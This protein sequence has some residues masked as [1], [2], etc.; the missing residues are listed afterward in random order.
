VAAPEGVQGANHLADV[1]NPSAS[2][3][4]ASA[5]LAHLNGVEVLLDALATI[6][7]AATPAPAKP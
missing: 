7:S 4:E 6:R 3:V 5:G 2:L 1:L